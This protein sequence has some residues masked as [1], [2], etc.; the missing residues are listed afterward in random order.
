[1]SRCF[2]TEKGFFPRSVEP[3]ADCGLRKE[4]SGKRDTHDRTGKSRPH[5]AYRKG[6]VSLD[7]RT[8]SDSDTDPIDVGEFFDQRLPALAADS[9]ALA[10]PGALELGIRPMAIV[11]DQGTWTLTVTETSIEVRPGDHGGS[12]VR[13]DAD[14]L[15]DMVHDLRTPMTLLTAGSLDME[16]GNLGDLLDWWV[17]LRSLIDGDAVHTAGSIGFRD[18]QGDPLD[19]HESFAPDDDPRDMAHFLAEAGYLHLRG[20][21]TEEEMAQVS[22]DMDTAEP[23]Y[24]PDDGRSWW[25]R[26]ATG[27]HRAV[28]LQWFQE[29]SPITAELLADDRF[30]AIGRL[31]SDGHRASAGGNRIEALLKP[32]GVVEGISDVP[33]H[34]DC[35]LGRHSYQCCGLTVGISVTGADERSGQLAVVAG[36]NRALVQPAFARPSWGLPLVDLPTR[37]G[38]VTVHTSCTM[39][40]SHPPVDQERR[41]MYTGF[42]L[43]PRAGDA[44]RPHID[45]ISRV[46]EQA[47]RVVSQAP[48][49]VG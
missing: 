28:R 48:G 18:R 8:R 16:R 15:T 11:T 9:A 46:R 30:L 38:D 43:P 7:L 1:M 17:V 26:T 25:A 32:I 37:T 6:M 4:E 22:A 3:S 31:T 27:E 19:L 41:V 42:S 23:N 49:H 13:L 2:R 47:H 44:A 12:L 21:F 35:S 29:Q 45:Q 36:S 5:L 40:M 24:R 33:W 14:E 20:V 34:K 10:I 39:H